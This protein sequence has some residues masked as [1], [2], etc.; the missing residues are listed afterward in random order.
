MI[1][2]TAH[3][4]DRWTEYDCSGDI[5]ERFNKSTYVG[6]DQ[7]ESNNI[8]Y[9]AID[10]ITFVYNSY[11]EC[12][13][14]VVKAVYGFSQSINIGIARKQTKLLA[15]LLKSIEIQSAKLVLKENT[16]VKKIEVYDLELAAL[17]EKTKAVKAMRAAAHEEIEGERRKLISL[18]R[19]HHT[20]LKKLHYSI[21]YRIKNIPGMV[22]AKNG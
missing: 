18:K 15:K 10:D 16:I 21:N 22:V 12:I 5:L 2:A 8:E 14:T 17:E 3:A 6:C 11:D 9:W 7:D 20:E 19:Q 1:R 4:R 13:I